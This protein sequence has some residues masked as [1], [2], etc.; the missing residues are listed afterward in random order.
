MYFSCVLDF[1]QYFWLALVY[2]QPRPD[3]GSTL[4][5]LQQVSAN[6]LVN[7]TNKF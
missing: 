3:F 6:T 4:Y 7:G 1:Y 5:E 2:C